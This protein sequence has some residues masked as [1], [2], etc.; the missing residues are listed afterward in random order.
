[1]YERVYKK[2]GARLFI[3]A[4]TD[5]TKGNCFKLQDGRFRLDIRK[6]IFVMRAVKQW[7]GLPRE[8]VAGLCLGTFKIGLNGCLSNLI[9]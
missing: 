7:R 3:R 2:D 4:C 8:V 6:K 5:K 9:K 1:M